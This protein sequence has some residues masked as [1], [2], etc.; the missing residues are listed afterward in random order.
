MLSEF[1]SFGF[2]SGQ[3]VFRACQSPQQVV[4]VRQLLVKQLWDLLH[5]SDVERAT[6]ADGRLVG[7]D[8]A[9]RQGVKGWL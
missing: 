6:L 7:F 8:Y 9:K 1:A 3:R 2:L 4:D 5:S